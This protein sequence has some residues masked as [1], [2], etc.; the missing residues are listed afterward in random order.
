[1]TCILATYIF[2][3]SCSA[4]QRGKCGNLSG[5]ASQALSTGYYESSLP[6][7]SPFPFFLTLLCSLELC[8]SPQHVI[9]NRYAVLS[10]LLAVGEEAGSHHSHS[11]PSQVC[12]ANHN[13]L[14]HLPL[15]YLS[16][17]FSPSH[18][19]FLSHTLPPSLPCRVHYC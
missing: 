15:Y 17:P 7:P 1:M 8:S 16:F 14:P 4:A 12:I 6:F 3:G 19:L 18:P 5:A 9:K 13:I 10:F 11:I 2:Y